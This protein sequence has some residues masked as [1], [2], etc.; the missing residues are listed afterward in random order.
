MMISQI[1]KQKSKKKDRQR[2]RYYVQKKH[3]FNVEHARTLKE[4]QFHYFDPIAA[5]QMSVN[6]SQIHHHMKAQSD[7]K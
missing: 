5:C 6:Y 3:S 4:K 2:N 1:Q 7:I